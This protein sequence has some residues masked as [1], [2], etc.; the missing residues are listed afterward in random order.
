MTWDVAIVGAGPGGLAAAIHVASRGLK[1]VV[2]DRRTL[3][4]D[5]A[6]GEGLM[7]PGLAALTQ[8]QVDVPRAECGR[9][10]AIR[11]VQEDGRHVEAPLSAPG[12]LGIRRVALEEAL[13]KRARA[14]GAELRQGCTVRRH[15]ERDGAVQL[16]T[17]G[18]EVTA[19]LV[20]AAD[21][22]H[23]PLRKA[24]GLEVA[25]SR[26]PRRFGLRRHFASAAWA[27]RVEVHFAEGLE[28]YVT[29]AGSE[30]VGVAFL[31][32]DGRVQPPLAFDA[33]L[34]RFPHLEAHLRGA[35]IDS[36]PMGAGPLLQR[37]RGLVRGRLVLLGD[38]AG[39]VDAITGEGLSLAFDQAKL[40]ATLLPAALDDPR[41][42]L[43]YERESRRAFRAYARLASSLVALARRPTLR[44][45]AL[46]RLIA[47]PALFAFLLR[48]L[49]KPRDAPG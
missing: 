30:R 27:P 1:C 28:A 9:F 21:G 19:R 31:W 22:L 40:I 46:N 15:H 42:L 44:R 13:T 16:E 17:D 37:T 23:S 47:N 14:V 36:K 8:M 49:T 20:I 29:P 39:Y 10:E 6:C 24:S 33:M 3:P 41:L 25:E 11:Y 34:E 26:G 38:A 4:I 48:H 7:P 45:M 32:E 2:I 43:A 18:G 35:P 12:G 5:K